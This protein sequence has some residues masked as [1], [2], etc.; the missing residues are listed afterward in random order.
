MLWSALA[1]RRHTSGWLRNAVIEC[2]L[3]IVNVPSESLAIA[4]KFTD[5]GATSFV[6]LAN[7][8]QFG[9][10]PTFSRSD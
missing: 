4:E 5:N 6:T 1:S 7:A 8:A 3:I 9:G 10:W 2:P